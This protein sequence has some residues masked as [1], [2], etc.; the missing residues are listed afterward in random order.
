LEEKGCNKH[1]QCKNY[2]DEIARFGIG[3]LAGK[4]LD[5]ILEVDPGDVKAKSIT[6]E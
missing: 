5:S 2:R 4:N 6:G 3:E 1:E